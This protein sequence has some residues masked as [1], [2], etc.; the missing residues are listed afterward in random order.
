M[1]AGLSTIQ[2]HLS[3]VEGK[4]TLDRS[5]PTRIGA[6]LSRLFGCWH[7]EL[8]RP[9]SHKGQAYRACL[10]CGANRR[11]NLESWEMQGDFYYRLPT[12]KHFR[13][14]NGLT[15]NTRSLHAAGAR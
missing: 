11:F 4:K 2:G 3:V 8:S 10:N 12:T 6:W 15:T 14:L 7:R 9:F 13:V 1:Q 5:L